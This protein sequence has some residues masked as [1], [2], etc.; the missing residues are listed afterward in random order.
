MGNQWVAEVDSSNQDSWFFSYGWTPDCEGTKT[1]FSLLS[2]WDAYP[3]NCPEDLRPQEI[4][5]YSPYDVFTYSAVY[6][7]FYFVKRRFVK[8]ESLYNIG[9]TVFVCVVL[10]T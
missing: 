10:C 5:K 7:V 4:V 3:V 1:G 8:L 9:I 2:G 6:P